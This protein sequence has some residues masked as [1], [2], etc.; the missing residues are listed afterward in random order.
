MQMARNVG[1]Q[2]EDMIRKSIPD[3]ALLYRIPDPAQSFGKSSKTRFSLKPPFDF[4][5][6][7]SHKRNLFALE[8]KTVGGKSI[9]FER[10][11]DDNGDIHFY[12]ISGL[13]SWSKYDGII[14][15]L[16]IEF[17]EIETTIFIDIEN[18]KQLMDEIPKKSFSF[19]DLTE[20]NVPYT[21]ISQTKA[22]TRY[23]YDIDSFLKSR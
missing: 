15:G 2:F 3:Y 7:D 1:K 6:W 13:S 5:I 22:R 21:V 17:R 4:I 14:C 16:V 10:T 9:S 8:M 23:T 19:H 11:K 12:Q 20:Y 18:F